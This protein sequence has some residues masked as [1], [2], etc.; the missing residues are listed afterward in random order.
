VASFREEL[1][2]PDIFKI[3]V[4]VYLKIYV[5]VDDFKVLQINFDLITPPLLSHH[6]YYVAPVFT[7]CSCS[8]LDFFKENRPELFH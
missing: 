7:I 4:T 6:R 1:D 5:E 3:C 2:Q 8:C